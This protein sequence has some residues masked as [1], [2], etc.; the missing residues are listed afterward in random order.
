[1]EETNSKLR[2]NTGAD[3]ALMMRF[4]GPMNRNRMRGISSTSFG[5]ASAG[6]YSAPAHATSTYPNSRGVLGQQPNRDQITCNRC[7]QVGHIARFCMAP[8]PLAQHNR[9]F[10]QPARRFNANLI[11]DPTYTAFSSEPTTPYPYF[12]RTEEDIDQ[13]L[14]VLYVSGAFDDKGWFFDSGASKHFSGDPDAFSELKIVPVQNTVTS[15]G[16]QSHAIAGHGTADVKTSS[17]DF[18]YITDVQ[19][20]P[21]LHKNL[22]SVGQIADLDCMVLFTKS[23]CAV[24]TNRKPYTVLASG[25]RESTNGLYHL[26]AITRIDSIQSFPPLPNFL[27]QISSS[28]E[29]HKVETQLPL[30][31]SAAE[32]AATHRAHLWHCRL[33]HLNYP[34]MISLSQNLSVLGL[35]KLETFK[36]SCSICIQG[37]QSRTVIP[38]IATHRAT[39]PL[40]L[41]HTDLCGPLP[42]KSLGGS[43]YFITFTDDYSRKTWIA[44]LRTKDQ[45]FQKF[46]DFHTLIEKQTPFRIRTLRSDRGGEFLS[47]TFSEYLRRYGITRQLTNAYTP[48][49]NG[50]VERKN[51]TILNRARCM[52]MGATF[53]RFC[54]QRRSKQ[55]ST[56]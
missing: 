44:F 45:A 32:I 51:R 16:G 22:L 19:Y 11:E 38:K 15:T 23:K 53:Q 14:A 27:T 3:E 39:S 9:S 36:P 21:G 1:M 54:G 34:D 52:L 43:S 6:S 12:A 26:D 56:W 35:P 25:S 31:N 7:G 24:L 20:V 18:Q 50:V 41:V 8:A 40:E 10:Q 30:E 13:A 46:V 28:I 37:K 4:R 29:S 48:H 49:Q 55:L 17:G 33:G 47:N 42:V 2:V 5:R